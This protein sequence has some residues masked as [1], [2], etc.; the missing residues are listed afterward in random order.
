MKSL[1][2]AMQKE[3]CRL[4]QEWKE[5]GGAGFPR[6]DLE[7]R[8]GVDGIVK[9]VSARSVDPDVEMMMRPLRTRI[10]VNTSPDKTIT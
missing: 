3:C 10:V 9:E 4:S 2:E 7:G 5:T 6:R 8:K 1:I